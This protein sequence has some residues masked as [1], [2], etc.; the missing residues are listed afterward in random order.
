MVLRL[1]YRFL[2]CQITISNECSRN[3]CYYCN[4]SKDRFPWNKKK[5]SQLTGKKEIKTYKG[6]SKMSEIIYSISSVQQPKD[7]EDS[8]RISPWSHNHKH[9]QIWTCQKPTLVVP[10][11]VPAPKRTQTF[12]SRM[13]PKA[14]NLK[15]EEPIS[16]LTGLTEPNSK[17]ICGYWQMS[18][19]S[20][21]PCFNMQFIFPNC[22]SRLS[23][24][25]KP[26][27]PDAPWYPTLTY[28]SIT[29]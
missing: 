23:F 4:I 15:L 18:P 5:K 3:N 27:N 22:K 8:V 7:W 29:L 21:N 25:K 26:D 19:W 14:L 11:L 2:Q 24:K 16:L 13:A 1:C 12:G 20:L 28:T 17:A 9:W 6:S 10:I